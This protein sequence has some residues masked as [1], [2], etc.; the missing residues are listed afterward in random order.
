MNMTLK[1]PPDTLTS[2]A[3]RGTTLRKATLPGLPL[4]RLLAAAGELD[5][6]ALVDGARVAGLRTR[7]LA[8]GCEFWCLLCADL[9]GPLRDSA[10][11]LLRL[12][13]AGEPAPHLAASLAQTSVLLLPGAPVCGAA[14]R[15]HLRQWLR[16]PLR[17]GKSTVFRFYDPQDLTATLPRLDDGARRAFLAPLGGVFAI[18]EGQLQACG[19][20]Q[21][22]AVAAV[23]GDAAPTACA[24]DTRRA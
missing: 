24:P 6:F 2:A 12:R 9:D 18:S 13:R 11:Y 8:A 4:G 15:A 14:L 3:A 7:L 20:L 17:N 19:A 22:S 1:L 16:A 5:V 23:P 21:P 10:P